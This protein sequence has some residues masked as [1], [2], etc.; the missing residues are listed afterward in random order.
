MQR[1][2]QQA[3]KAILILGAGPAGLS[4]AYEL[5]KQRYLSTVWDKNEVVGGLARTIE[6]RGYR[7]D[8]GPHRFFTK[9][10]EVNALWHNVLGDDA[11]RVNRLTRI[12]YNQTFFHY[13][14][15]PLNAL[16]GL[17]IGTSLRAV[18]SYLHAK[19]KLAGHTARNFEELV[20]KQFG[21]VLY[22]VFFKT[23]TEKVWGLP[24]TSIGAEW[25]SQRIKGLSLGTAV[26]NALL[27]PRKG[28]RQIKT[29]IDCFDY[30]RTGAGLV[31]EKMS[32]TLTRFGSSIALNT[33]ATVIHRRGN[34][35]THVEAATPRGAVTTQVTHLF[36]SIPL[37]EFVLKLHPSAPEDVLEAARKLYYRDHITVNLILSR[38]AIFPDN[39]IYVHSPNVRM[40]RIADYGNFSEEML[41]TKDTTCISVEYFVFAH[42]DLWSLPD[43]DLVRLA[44]EELNTVGLVRP[45]EILD[46]FVV[47][48]KDSYP[49]YYVGHRPL[50]EKIKNYV[51]GLENVTLIGRG[52]MYKYNN[53][54]HS[55]LTGLLAARKY[56][57]ESHN[58]WEINTD[59]DYH[60]EKHIESERTADG[61]QIANR[62]WHQSLNRDLEKSS[63]TTSLH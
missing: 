55:I 40:A 32:R 41:A 43:T 17:G 51:D 23:Y 13:P 61:D 59:E 54:D 58:I 8:I 22:R 26:W 29:L 24:C 62:A 10:D 28:R 25:A 35:I 30:P 15:K 7:F 11:L 52:G 39:W 4:C 34:R 9:H 57:G 27:G 47:R 20:T 3:D 45:H 44:T 31:Y 50:F 5:S 49:V 21:A 1:P 60:E 53:Q 42:E 12:F 33:T 56:L 46:G 37:T 16:L 19:Y 36:S 14:L 63:P 38:R 18:V 6:Y 2:P 48:E